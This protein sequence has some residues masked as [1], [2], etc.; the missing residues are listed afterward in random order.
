VFDSADDTRASLALLYA[1]CTHDATLAIER[2]R[3]AQANE[4]GDL[5]GEWTTLPEAAFDISWRSGDGPDTDEWSFDKAERTLHVYGKLPANRV[6]VEVQ[7]EVE[8]AITI[9]DDAADLQW[10]YV[11][12][13]YAVSLENVQAEVVLPL[14]AG[15]QVE[16][17]QNVYAWGHG[18][19]DGTVDIRSDGTIMFNVPRVSPLQY[20]EARVMFPV[21]WLSNLSDEEKRAH[22]G[23]LQFEYTARYEETWADRAAAAEINKLSLGEVLLGLAALGLVASLILWWRFGREHPPVFKDQYAIDEP[24]PYL[25][26]AVMARLWRWNHESSRDIVVSVFDMRRRRAANNDEEEL[27]QNQGVIDEATAILLER[28]YELAEGEAP[29]AGQKGAEEVVAEMP[30]ETSAEA[31]AETSAEEVTLS[32]SQ[33]EPRALSTAVVKAARRAP[34]PFLEAYV[35]WQASLTA[36]VEPYHFFDETSRK[37]QK[38]LLYAAVVM[39]VLGVLSLI[40]ASKVAGVCALAAA[41]AMGVVGNYVQRRSADGNEIAA[42]AKALRNWMRDGGWNLEAA[43]LTACE[44]VRLVDYA[45]I[46]RILKE[47]QRSFLGQCGG[48]RTEQGSAESERAEG[49][50]AKDEPE[51]GARKDETPNLPKDGTVDLPEVI[52][53]R[54]LQQVHDAFHEALRIAHLR[55]EVS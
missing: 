37:V 31:T 43:E 17:M 54:E 30:T 48:K 50:H 51:E 44:R 55:A 25:P 9:Y 4:Q 18:P 39:A 10:T 47:L 32:L 35:A 19:A 20:A 41:L 22:Q 53:A 42:H 52:E 46:F 36:L 15:A 2:V 1:G 12:K 5:V 11:P 40:F 33:L 3:V 23:E 7:Y 26:L 24:A 8:G 27:P 13:D 29:T 34:R 16:P 38:I 6:I 14:P 49:E 21:G 28:L 45:F